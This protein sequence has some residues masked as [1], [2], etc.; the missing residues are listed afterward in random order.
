MC[1]IAGSVN[2][3]TDEKTLEFIRHR[4]P[5][6]QG[7]VLDT[8]GSNQ[9]YFGHTRLSIVDLSEAGNQPMYSDCG[10][11]CIIFNG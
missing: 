8:V 7:L 3:P 9:V 5:D 10:N 2:T 6:S 4:G 1:G 11:Y